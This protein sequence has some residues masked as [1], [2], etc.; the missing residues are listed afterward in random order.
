MCKKNY[1]FENLIKNCNLF[2]NNDFFGINIL[3]TRI[4]FKY[5]ILKLSMYNKKLSAK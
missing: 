2:L 5:T 3:L 4:K 1:V